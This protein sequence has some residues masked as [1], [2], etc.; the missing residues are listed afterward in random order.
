M[1]AYL[2]ITTLDVAGRQNNREHHAILRMKRDY[3][4]VVVV[5]RS[6]RQRADQGGLFGV[7][8]TVHHEDGVIYV[9]VDPRLNPKDGAVRGLVHTTGQPSLARRAVGTLIDTA[10]IMRDWMT[11]NA[12]CHAA[13]QHLPGPV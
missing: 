1:T 10:G 3:S 9:G 11:I 5:Y 4:P 2:L 12:L 13:A 7:T 8:E 6:R